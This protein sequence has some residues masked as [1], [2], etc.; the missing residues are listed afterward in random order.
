MYFLG[1]RTPQ[2]FITHKSFGGWEGFVW[3]FKKIF[4]VEEAK[5]EGPVAGCFSKARFSHVKTHAQ[6]LHP[7][8]LHHSSHVLL[9]HINFISFGRW[10][11][12]IPFCFS[13]LTFTLA[14]PDHPPQTHSR[15]AIYESSSILVTAIPRV[16]GVWLSFLAWGHEI[17]P[18]M[19][20]SPLGLDW[21][22]ICH[23]CSAEVE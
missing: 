2:E 6:S 21:I 17:L 4:Y 20:H 19:A 15:A 8:H 9:H 13:H 5:E 10:R 12:F 11:K 3:D 1:L 23:F 14:K 7:A 18:A 16:N 22:M